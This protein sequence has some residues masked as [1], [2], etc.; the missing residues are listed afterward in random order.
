[1]DAFGLIMM[2]LFWVGVVVLAIWLVGL[3]FPVAKKQSDDSDPPLAASEVRQA[4]GEL[5]DEQDQSM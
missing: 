4:R 2:L 5:T 1:M 3:L